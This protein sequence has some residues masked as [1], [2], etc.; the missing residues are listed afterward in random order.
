MMVRIEV[1]DGKG[2]HVFKQDYS[3]QGITCMSD[4]AQQLP[5]KVFTLDCGIYGFHQLTED[6][7]IYR[8]RDVICV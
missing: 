1:Q 3:L 8:K 6:G 2:R 7:A 4:A 5:K